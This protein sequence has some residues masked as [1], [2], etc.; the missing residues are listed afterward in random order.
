[1]EKD[2][3][4]LDCGTSIQE[5]RQRSVRCGPCQTEHTRKL[6]AERSRK[7]YIPKILG[8]LLCL[9]CGKPVERGKYKGSKIRCEPCREKFKVRYSREYEEVIVL[10]SC[11]ECQELMV[12]ERKE[13]GHLGKYRNY[14]PTCRPKHYGRRK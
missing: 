11:L 10:K 8:P 2:R 13:G 3:I 12:I 4:C 5:R 7:K 14:C 9:D 1:M 6:V